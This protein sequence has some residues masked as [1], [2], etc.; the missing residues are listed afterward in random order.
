MKKVIKKVKRKLL[1][2]VLLVV[3]ILNCTGCIQAVEIPYSDVTT[4]DATFVDR[5]YYSQLT[6]EE[7]LVYREIYQGVIDHEEEI[8]VHSEDAENANEILILVLYDFGEIFWA[9][10]RA[11][12]SAYEESIWNDGYTIV[13]PT[14]VYSLEER[15]T[16]EQEIETVVSRVINSVPAEYTEYETIKY[17]YE[18]LINNASYVEGAPDNQN[19]Y[20]ALVSGQTVCAGYAKANQYLLNRMG[21]YCTYVIGTAALEDEFEG[22]AWNIVRC[23]GEYYYVDITWADPIE[24]ETQNDIQVELLYEYLCCSQ[25]QLKDTH[26]IDEKYDYPKCISEDLNYY[27]LNQMY[28]ESVDRNQLLNDMYTSIDAKERSTVFKFSDSA[29]YQEANTLVLQDI[30]NPATERLARRYGLTEVMYYYEE[31]EPMNKLV[32]YWFYE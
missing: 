20:S 5:F 31:Q 14:Y 24:E 18:Y 10:G 3:L 15:K 26:R 12:S 2:A 11:T 25:A 1:C 32:I 16:K 9:D 4:E 27:R 17:V 8:Y 21:I 29:L 30:I 7:Q 22:H 6:E 13:K 23:D 19:L 28:Y